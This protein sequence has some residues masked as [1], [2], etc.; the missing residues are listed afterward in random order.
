M[1]VSPDI[2]IM[3]KTEQKAGEDA[4]F[5]RGVERGK[6]ESF[7]MRAA[8]PIAGDAVEAAEWPRVDGGHQFHWVRSPDGTEI[9]AR[10]VNGGWR[11]CG[12]NSTISTEALIRSNWAYI[13][14]C[15]RTADTA[16]GR[17]YTTAAVDNLLR[18]LQNCVDFWPSAQNDDLQERTHIEARDYLDRCGHG[19]RVAVM[20]DDPT[21]IDNTAESRADGGRV[22]QPIDMILHC[23]LCHHQHI[24]APEPQ[25]DWTN[26]PHKSHL[27]HACGTIWRPA[28]VATNGVQDIYSYGQSDTWTPNTADDTGNFSAKAA[29]DVFMGHKK[30][31]AD[32]GKA[33]GREW[34]AEKE[35]AVRVLREA[36]RREM[37]AFQACI[38]CE[39]DD[40][41]FEQAASYLFNAAQHATA[42]YVLTQVID[43]MFPTAFPA[44]PERREPRA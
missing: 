1:S 8:E 26:P 19:Y 38:T 16:R 43:I 40:G 42:F 41:D 6:F 37:N 13:G 31:T 34:T 11:L 9:P 24:D 28:R 4:A 14:P 32:G 15:M 12:R 39:N 44:E 36:H 7:A 10:W 22:E 35:R 23:P 2:C 29:L 30:D 17:S 25:S 20:P 18:L 5:Q 3:T 33:E 21:S 27:C